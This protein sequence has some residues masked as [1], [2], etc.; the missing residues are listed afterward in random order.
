MPLALP[1]CGPLLRLFSLIS[2]PLSGIL[3]LFEFI[4]II[5]LILF[6]FIVL[7]AFF[8]FFFSFHFFLFVI[9]YFFRLRGG[10]HHKGTDFDIIH[11]LTGFIKDGE[12]LL[13]LGRPGAGCSTLLRVLSNQR[14]IFKAVTGDI[15]YGG[16]PADDFKVI[17]T[18]C[19]NNI[20]II[21]FISSFLRVFAY[22]FRLLILFKAICGRGSV[23]SRGRCPLSHPDGETNINSSIEV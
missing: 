22:F 21:I 10:F 6:L 20:A 5:Y 14:S 18:P 9:F 17:I 13:V 19:I 16:L 8:L 12:M 4:F 7:F 2:T 3:L 15:F 1:L 23:Y 11:N